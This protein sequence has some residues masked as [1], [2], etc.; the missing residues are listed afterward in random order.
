MFKWPT[1]TRT[2]TH[3][4]LTITFKKKIQ[5][6]LLVDGIVETEWPWLFVNFSIKSKRQTG[7]YV[8]HLGSV[9]TTRRRDV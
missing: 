8:T 3:N 1:H 5:I 4:P 7:R 2:D 6:N 9:K